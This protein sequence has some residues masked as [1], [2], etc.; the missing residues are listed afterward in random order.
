[1]TESTE[2]K[3]GASSSSRPSAQLLPLLA[4][5]LAAVLAARNLYRSPYSASDLR[6]TPDEVEYAV[7]AR[8][9]ATRG[10]YDLDID[11]ASTAPHSTPWFSA[12][13][14]PAYLVSPDEVG[15]AIWVVFA[16]AVVGVIVVL[17]IGTLVAGP[18]GG[19]LAAIAVLAL[20]PYPYISRLIMTD[21]P[22]MVLG[23]V[24]LW[25][26][27]R[28]SPGRARLRESLIAGAL[29][30]SAFALRSVYLTML[31]PFAWRALRARE[32]RG[33]HLTALLAP[34]LVVLAA[35]A[36]YNQATFGDWQRTGYQ[37]WCAIPYDYPDLVLSFANLRTNLENVMIPATVGA[38]AIGVLGAAAIGLRRPPHGRELV[39]YAL[40]TAAPISVLHLL[41]FY[42]SPRFHVYLVVLCL[43]LG[44]IGLATLVP[45][46]WRESTRA[47]IA[48]VVALVIALFVMPP[49][50][51]PAPA[52]RRAVDEIQRAT[53]SDAV[54][55]SG[56]EPVYLA[57]FEPA[58]SKRT[59]LAASREVEFASK[60]LVKSRVERA[61]AAPRS[62]R[63]HAASGLLAHGGRWAVAHTADEMHDEIAAWVRAGRPVFLETSFITN[64]ES[65]QRMLGAALRLEAPYGPLVRVVANG[66]DSGR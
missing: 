16:F 60:V 44:G 28:W 6:L 21:G 62:A 35:N 42:S 5:V 41:Y 30:A 61:A 8:R 12:L 52:R 29:I 50:D 49:F 10:T 65:I 56:L 4:L 32:R 19:A 64:P 66:S 37:Y 1:M 24:G 34:L 27:L 46:R 57:A 22:A 43:A 47:G 45:L 55:I 51:L 53:P 26:F 20:P 33:A 54:I 39:G 36:I 40:A 2:G 48:A 11:G 7:C 3:S 23:L 17:R 25:L 9:L 15:N 38:L 14:A 58:D 18:L 63:D 59:Y 31:V 13:L